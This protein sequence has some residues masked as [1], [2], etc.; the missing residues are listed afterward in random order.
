MA[1]RRAIAA[2]CCATLLV[3]AAASARTQQS[4]QALFRG[5]LLKDSATTSGVKR[6][7]N[8]NAGFIAPDTTF[9]DLTGDGKTDAVVTVQNGGAAG[10]VAV[11]VLSADGSKGGTLRALFRS[12]SLYQA[13]VRVSAATLTIAQPIFARGDDLCCTRRTSER[14]YS[15]DAKSRTFARRATRTVD[16]GA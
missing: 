1:V 16:N 10:A 5:I 15:W 7:L 4:P 14:D 6:L 12:Q 11:Y 3:A 2:A 9:A 8:T 13:V